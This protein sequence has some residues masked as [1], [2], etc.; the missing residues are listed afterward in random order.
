MQTGIALSSVLLCVDVRCGASVV[1]R[2]F[3]SFLH[4]VL[5]RELD[6]KGVQIA[7]AFSEACLQMTGKGM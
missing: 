4:G 3:L 7:N 1:L 6:H 5:A 2:E